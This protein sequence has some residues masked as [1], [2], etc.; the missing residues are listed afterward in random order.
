MHPNITALFSVKFVILNLKYLEGRSILKIMQ[1]Y[2][3]IFHL[4]KPDLL[5]P[6]ELKLGQQLF[7]TSLIEL[8]SF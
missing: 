7:L 1:F 3:P 4:V 2:Y 8:I 6:N 5:S